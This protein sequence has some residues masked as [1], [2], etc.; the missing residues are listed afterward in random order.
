M[1]DYQADNL[2]SVLVFD[3]D[4][5]LAD[6]YEVP[7]WLEKIRAFDASPYRDALPIYDMAFMSKVVLALKEAGWRIVVTTALSKVTTPEYDEQV[8]AAKLEWLAKY[9]FPYDEFHAVA[10]TD[11]KE[12]FTKALGGRQILVD[13]NPKVREDWTIGDTI[14]ASQSIL[15]EL[16]ALLI[17]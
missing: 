2:L 13:D 7:N 17:A 16:Q 3:M 14:D 1:R 9:E 8:T 11:K 4:G 12:D 15:G 5:T 6:F 10:Y